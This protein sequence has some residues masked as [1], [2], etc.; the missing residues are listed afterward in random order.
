MRILLVTIGLCLSGCRGP[1]S[2]PVVQRLDDESQH[3]VDKAWMN[4]LTPPEALDRLTLLDAIMLGQLH[5]TGVDSLL[6]ISEKRVGENTVIMEIRYDR[7]NPADE[8][9]SVTYVD[10]EGNVIRQ[11]RF[12]REEVENEWAHL[13]SWEPID[14]SKTTEE[15]E[16]AARRNEERQAHIEGIQA[17]LGMSPDDEESS[18]SNEI[19][20][21]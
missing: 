15:A 4:I 5:E 20:T 18:T 3:K 19:E 1:L 9:Y 13:V 8:E 14:E 17:I 2:S 7:E 11:E 12:A 21:P 6:F 16:A 10:T